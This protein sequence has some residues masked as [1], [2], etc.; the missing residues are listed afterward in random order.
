MPE[1][2]PVTRAFCP[3]STLRIGHEGRTTAGSCS[4]NSTAFIARPPSRGSRFK[5]RNGR[6]RFTLRSGAEVLGRLFPAR[7]QQLGDQRGPTGL[8]R[9]ADAAPRV[10]V[11]VFVKQQV[12]PEV[13]VVLVL[14]RLPEDG[15][16]AALVRQENAGQAAGQLLGHALDGDEPAGTR[17][18]LDLEVVAVV[19]VKLLERLDDQ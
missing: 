9:R 12:I 4:C 3:L 5:G 16:P 11:E 14:G 18:A 8:M 1:L 10:A 2:A 13:R 6:R 7:L 19:V 15:P 17:R